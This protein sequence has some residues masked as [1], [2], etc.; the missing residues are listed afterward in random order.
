ML[1]C[2]KIM[3]HNSRQTIRAWLRVF[4][5]KPLRDKVAWSFAYAKVL[6]PNTSEG[7]RWSERACLRG[8][9]DTDAYPNERYGITKYLLME[10]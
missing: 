3:L 9:P 10:V 4:L 6:K 5:S 7:R 8:M 1:K 2:G